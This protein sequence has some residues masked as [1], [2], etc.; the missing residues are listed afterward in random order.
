MMKSDIGINAG[1]I[2]HLLSVKGKLSI[3]QIG[4]YTHYKD[5]F[6][7]MAIGWLSRENKILVS[8]RNGTLYIELNIVRSEIYYS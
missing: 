5:S 1:S 3:R 2:W 6:I 4:E 7:L 8:D